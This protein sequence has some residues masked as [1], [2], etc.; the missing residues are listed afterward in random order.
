MDLLER[1]GS[2]KIAILARK[3]G[4]RDFDEMSTREIAEEEGLTRERIR[5]LIQEGLEEIRYMAV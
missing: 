2:R 1:L 3:V 5:K 4:L